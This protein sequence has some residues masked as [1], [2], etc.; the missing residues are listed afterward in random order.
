MNRHIF[1]YLKRNELTDVGL[2]NRLFISAFIQ[3]YH[4]MPQRN[5]L[6]CKYVIAE[7]SA[8][9]E[10]LQAFDAQ[11]SR[12]GCEYSLEDLTELFEFVISP[13]DRKISGAIY[14]PKAIR[15][16]IVDEV[17]RGLDQTQL[18]HK[19]F[20]D[21]ACGCGGF[22]LTI[23]ILIHQQTGK[24]FADIYRD[25]ILGVDIQP[26][27]IERTK[28]LL[29]LLALM[30][31]E[32]ENF[33]FNL[34]VANSLS[35]D[36][37]S[38][39]PIDIVVGNP[40]YVCA[41]NMTDENRALLKNWKVCNAGNSNLYIPFFHIA[42]EIIQEGG[43]VGFITV[44]SFLTSLNGRAL[45]DYFSEQLLDIKIVDFRGCQLF[46]GKST[47][48]CLFFLTKTESE[49]VSYCLNPSA[50]LSDSFDYG[51]YPY[52]F[53]NNRK[54]W[55]FNLTVAPAE[56]NGITLH[57]FCKTRHGIATLKNK[58]Y[59]FKP[60]GET[61]N[62]YVMEKDGKQFF[63]EKGICRDIVNSN[64]FNSDVKLENIV[65]KVIYPYQLNEIGQTVII[66]EDE[67]SETYPLAYYYLHSQRSLLAERDKGKTEHYPAWYAYGRTQSLT[68]PRYKLFFPK[69]ANRKLRCVVSD[70]PRLL[71]YNGIS[72][73]DDDLDKIMTLK[74]VL[75]SDAF[76]SF[77][78]ANAKP[79]SSGY[80]SIT[81]QNVLNYVV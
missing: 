20:A 43:K 73:V 79:Y 38:I 19:R 55:K 4:L 77:V 51:Q 80:Y 74:Q 29:A 70:D 34:Y 30:N 39:A 13:S 3:H 40:P 6:L 71:L 14:T 48:T 64:K 53:L 24:K 75:E 69:I 37:A 5:A 33:D 57:D 66:P 1:T 68:M 35:F 2:V 36:F 21:I 23:A 10:K 56:P 18:L 22:F 50:Q 47:Y 49:S 41:R 45:R 11:L 63:I 17:I 72:F 76:W 62:C 52:K 28:L 27:A 54:G 65:E 61:A 58:V 7:E 9:Y 32:D 16:R 60:E 15:E 78:T 12:Y 31:G 46:R 25:N 59:V 81:G 67:L 42:A 26:Y 8:E 44:N